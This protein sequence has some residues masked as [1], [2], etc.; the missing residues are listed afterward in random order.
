MALNNYELEQ[1]I[2]KLERKVCCIAD[3]TELSDDELLRMSNG[4]GVT[5][6]TL[7]EG[8]VTD[9]ILANSKAGALSTATI[10]KVGIFD[11]YA[12]T[13]GAAS[14]SA[15]TFSNKHIIDNGAI[16]RMSLKVTV[17]NVD[18]S[19]AASHIGIG[20]TGSQLTGDAGAAY[21]GFATA[22]VIGKTAHSYGLGNSNMTVTGSGG[23]LVS[24]NDIIDVE[25]WNDL[26]TGKKNIRVVNQNTGEWLH[27]IS[28]TTEN[29]TNL[30]M[31]AGELRLVLVNITVILLELSIRSAVP[32]NPLLQAIGDSYSI[33]FGQTY[34]ETFE[35]KFSLLTPRNTVMSSG[36]GGYIY[37]MNK[38]ALQEVFKINPKYIII[39]SILSQFYADYLVGDPDNAN[40]MIQWNSLMTAIIENGIVPIHIK[41]APGI[42]D[43]NRV[44][45]NTFLD[46]QQLVYPTMKILDL[47][48][49]PLAYTDVSHPSP[50]SYTIIANRVYS[51]IQSL[52]F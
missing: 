32:S 37:T 47:T 13:G 17:L 28:A 7:E 19:S 48:A 26:V 18:G 25:V 10:D 51:L 2:K 36:N 41:W 6:H 24:A 39:F 35:P 21:N 22:E 3:N 52:G 14:S 50:A 11:R 8:G 12:V 40:Y 9:G 23:T 46:A 16:Y 33:G 44:S 1:R 31:I 15:I 45:W 42:Y 43:S 34:V 38:K 4:Q 30:G 20:K 29:P 27:G 5:Y 49:E